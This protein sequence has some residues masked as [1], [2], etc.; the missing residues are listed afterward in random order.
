MRNEE[1]QPG[2]IYIC[3]EWDTALGVVCP[4]GKGKYN[5]EAFDV[6]EA[7]YYLLFTD[8]W[9]GVPEM[10]KDTAY[11][12]IRVENHEVEMYKMVYPGVNWDDLEKLREEVLR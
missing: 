6:S 3:P 8:G 2:D 4:V 1:I 11:A 5:V 9:C 12:I 7:P 10:H